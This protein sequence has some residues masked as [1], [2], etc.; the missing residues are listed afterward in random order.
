LKIHVISDATGETAER[1]VRAAMVQ[2]EGAAVTVVRRRNVRT[3]EQ[4]RA[5]VAEADARDSIVVHSLVSDKL[6]R[7]IL[8]ECRLRGVDALDMLGPLL[9]RLALHLKLSPQEKPGLLEQL[10][11]AK[12][13][14]IEAVEFAFRHD[15]GQNAEDLDRAEIVLVGVSRTMKTPTMLYLAYRG[16][17]VA[18]VPLV[19]GLALPDGLAAYPAA[20][21]ICL[22]TAPERLLDLRRVRAKLEAIPMQSYASP[23]A[24]REDIRY[25]RQECSAH[26][27]RT[28]DVTAK[29]VEEVGR[30][31]IALI[32]DQ[33]SGRKPGTA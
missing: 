3:P 17:F 31:I 2:F 28:V 4:V 7:L 12:S 29:S 25:A 6:R 18:N 13:R 20:R 21:V 26:G 8:E 16:W 1:V 19:P 10:Q 9:D 5:A 30:E 22:L 27:W 11:E 14:E 23:E 24:V 32:G 15:D 33:G